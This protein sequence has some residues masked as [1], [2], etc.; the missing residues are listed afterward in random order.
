[1][2]ALPQNRNNLKSTGPAGNLTP[3][4]CFAWLNLETHSTRR[5]LST[6][7]IYP[8]SSESH[9]LQ[10][11]IRQTTP[12]VDVSVATANHAVRFSIREFLIAIAGVACILG[13]FTMYGLF[14]ASSIAL[15]IGVLLIVRGRRAKK[16]WITRTGIAVSILSFC[17]LGV[18]MAGWLLFGIGPIY[19]PAAY[20]LE[21]TR[22]SEVADADTSDAK[23]SGLGS[24]IDTEHV[25]RLT[26]SSDQ[27][28]RVIADYGLTPVRAENVPQSFWRAFPGWWR[29]THNKYSRYLSTPNFPAQSRGPDGDHCF[30][31]FDP[32]NE[33]FYVWYKFNF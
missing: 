2:A 22:M 31:M 14:G 16:T 32:K 17:T 11:V 4:Q 9:R 28:D 3:T 6:T 23:I 20:Q 25:W 24:F 29:P 33:R 7:D 1:V 19:S 5:R 12:T 18:M 15:I 13:G 27:I 21:F 8:S 30:T 26:L 10:F